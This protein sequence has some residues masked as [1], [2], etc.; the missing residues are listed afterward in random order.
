[1]DTPLKR[2]RKRRGLKQRVVA[3]GAGIR[4]AYYCRIENGT[5]VASAEVAAK[6]AKFFGG[7]IDEREILYPERFVTQNEAA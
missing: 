7:I 6:I 1:M 4:P 2:V 3:E 5:S